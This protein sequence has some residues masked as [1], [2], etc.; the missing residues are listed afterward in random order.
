L[1]LL[2]L[3]TFTNQTL[4]YYEKNLFDCCNSASMK[5]FSQGSP[6]YGAGMKFN[7]N[8]D[9]NTRGLLLGTKFGFVLVNQEL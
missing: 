7:L 3:T 6:D 2:K 9:R 5:S 8:E 4:I 1:A